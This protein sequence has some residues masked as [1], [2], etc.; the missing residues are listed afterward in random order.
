MNTVHTSVEK[1]FLTQGIFNSLFYTI[2]FG[3]FLIACNFMFEMVRNY[4]FDWWIAVIPTIA[5]FIIGNF[6]T[7]FWVYQNSGILG[8]GENSYTS[9][10]GTFVM[11]KTKLATS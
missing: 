9:N 6:Y 3:L 10:K 8:E 1:N 7:L 2:P 4:Y 11:S 5:I